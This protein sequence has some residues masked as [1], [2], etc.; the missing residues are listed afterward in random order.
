MF[1]FLPQ[2]LRSVGVLFSPICPEGWAD[3][4]KKNCPDCISETVRCRKLNFGRDIG[5][6]RSAMLFCDL[7]LTLS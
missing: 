4:R 3:G 1:F 6:C 7:D 5:E 2:P